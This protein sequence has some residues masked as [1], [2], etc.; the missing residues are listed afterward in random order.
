MALNAGYSYH[1]RAERGGPSVLAYLTATFRHSEAGVWALRLAAGEVEVDG[2]RATGS[3]R[4]RPGQEVVWHR[5]PWEEPDAPLEFGVLFED[6]SLLAVTKPAGLPTLPGGGFYEHTLLR[7][8][9]AQF[10]GASPLHRLGR[11]TSGLVLFAREGAAG[12]ALSAAWR[13]R[14]VRK[15]YL[16]LAAGV[17]GWDT[18]EIT[19]PIGPVAHPRLGEV[20]A[21]HPAGK[22]SHSAAR[23]L[24]R[25]TQA[26]PAGETLLAVDIRTGRPH[27]I[28]I[29]AAWAGFPLVGDPLYAPGGAPLPGL[30][31]LPGDGG[32]L[33]HAWR[34]GFRHP[35]SGAWTQLEAAP[36][37]RLQV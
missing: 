5:P 4:L 25:R 15:T 3:E 7:R 13:E 11:G 37:P 35:A 24:E 18:L 2:V 12:A 30:P 16:A 1:S 31:G 29:H 27:Q 28:R 23:V 32:Y 22:A 17:P 26:G 36:P 19:A 21:A 10:P 34:L 8:V 33:L 9:R 14:E 6:A 20:Y